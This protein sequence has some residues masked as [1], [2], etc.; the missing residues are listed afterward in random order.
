MR[1]L[2]ALSFALMAGIAFAAEP[3]IRLVEKGGAPVA[4]EVT[5]LSAEVLAALAKRPA[6]DK[7]WP[8]TL[9]MY[10]GKQFQKGQPP[11]SGSYQVVEGTLRF[12]PQ[13]P[14]RGGLAF[15]VEV[16][17]PALRPETSPA[18]YERV[19]ELPAPPK[20]EAP[21]VTM[22]FPSAAT[23][24][25]NQLRFY[26]HFVTPMVLGE[27]YDHLSLLKEDGQPVLRPFLE[28]GEELWD[29]SRTRLTLLIDPGRIKRGLSPR[30][31]HGPVLEA[32]GK[33]TLVVTK[34]WH[35]ASGQSTAEDF[36]KSFTAGPPVETA[37]DYK[38][39]KIASPQSGGR[40]PLVVVFPQ[41]LDRALVERTITLVGPEGQPVAGEVTVG[42]DERSW[43]FK[44]EQGWV[45]GRHELVIETTLEDLAGNR[46]NRPFEV[47]EFREI[48]KTSLPE[49]VRLP[50]DIRPAAK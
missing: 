25:E 41:P 36:R 40:D 34:G 20:G 23:L 3:E 19:F 30:E 26:L 2:A 38:S 12:T 43:H 9:S 49:Y 50:F 42:K 28:I 17:P 11:L 5:G 31:E 45:A 44:S 48:D 18:R 27:A 8:R 4:I 1:C 46:I 16:F 10:V 6:D 33:Y 29:T 32:G 21:R 14:L 22:I 24:P 13:F 39:W 37:I 15:R 35:D 7:A 47:D